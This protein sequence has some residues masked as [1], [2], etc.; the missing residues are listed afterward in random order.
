MPLSGSSPGVHLL[1]HSPYQRIDE[2]LA[3]APKNIPR[4]TYCTTERK[5]CVKQLNR[6]RAVQHAAALSA[7]CMEISRKSRSSLRTAHR[8]R[9]EMR[10]IESFNDKIREGG[11]S[12]VRRVM[13]DGIGMIPGARALLKLLAAA[14]D[15]SSPLQCCRHASD[16]YPSVLWLR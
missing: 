3:G 11:M 7:H 2:T 15:R 5:A 13:H 6:I 16:L 14:A 10:L 12:T 9:H 1:A 4:G 8:S